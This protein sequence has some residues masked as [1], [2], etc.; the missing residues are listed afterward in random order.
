MAPPKQDR[1]DK[2]A[3]AVEWLTERLSAGCVESDTL[4][5]DALNAG[6]S[7]RTYRRARKDIHVVCTKS[8]FGEGGKWFVSLPGSSEHEDRGF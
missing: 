2:L 5:Q 7:K 1:G 8:R 3:E 6:I 4:E